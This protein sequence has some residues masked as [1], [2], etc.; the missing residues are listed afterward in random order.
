MSTHETEADL[1]AARQ[2]DQSS[3]E[4]R[5]FERSDAAKVAAVAALADWYDAQPNWREWRIGAS[6]RNAVADP[7]AA[8]ARVRAETRA[9]VA[10]EI[11]RAIEAAGVKVAAMGTP[12]FAQAIQDARIARAKA[13]T[14]D[15]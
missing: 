12:E 1:E 13:V 3:N 8:L 4:T 9:E 10:W 6:I 2:I 11:A 7:D 14:P 5:A 15:V